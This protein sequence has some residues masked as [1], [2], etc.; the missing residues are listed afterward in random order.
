MVTTLQV[1]PSS[2]DPDDLPDLTRGCA[3]VA[4]CLQGV[5]GG[6]RL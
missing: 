3:I 6:W 1:L 2:Y 5:L 4:W